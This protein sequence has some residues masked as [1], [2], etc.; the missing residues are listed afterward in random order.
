MQFDNYFVSCSVS[1]EN[2]YKYLTIIGNVK[3]PML[4]K[5]M[6]MLAPNPIDRMTN[7]SGSGLPFPCAEIAFDN[8]PNRHII[9]NSG[10][11]SMKF[12][13]PNSYY[14]QDGCTKILPSIFFILDTGSKKEYIRFE[15]SHFF[16]LSPLDFKLL[17]MF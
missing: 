12:K 7:Y 17:S 9:N 10:S 5:Q 6:L 2:D 13:Y 1:F 11:F 8:T 3:N 4:Y 14:A 16:L 15:N